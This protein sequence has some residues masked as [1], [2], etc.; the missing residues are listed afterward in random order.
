M[1]PGNGSFVSLACADGVIHVFTSDGRRALPPLALDTELHKHACIGH[2]LMAITTTSRCYVWY[3]LL[4][5][6]RMPQSIK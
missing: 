4:F 5:V 3:G 2:Y 6:I 1:R